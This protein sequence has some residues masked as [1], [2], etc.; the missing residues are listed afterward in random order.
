ML[1][2]KLCLFKLINICTIHFLNLGRLLIS[3]QFMFSDEICTIVMFF[4]SFLYF[5]KDNATNKTNKILLPEGTYFSRTC[6]SGI[7]PWCFT[8]KL[9]Q[10]EGCTPL[11]FNNSENHI[12]VWQ[13]LTSWTFKITEAYGSQHTGWYRCGN[14]E[15]YVNVVGKNIW[16]SNKGNILDHCQALCLRPGSN[17]L[18]AHRAFGSKIDDWFEFVLPKAFLYSPLV[19]SLSDHYAQ[20]MYH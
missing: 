8:S 15:V 1:L 7:Q 5:D 3:A 18:I 13:N 6:S 9:Q 11:L 14:A 2:R 12:M 4:F 19:L 16:N 20:V 17:F 10:E